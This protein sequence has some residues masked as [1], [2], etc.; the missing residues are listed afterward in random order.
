M[1]QDH[2]EALR[3][4][5]MATCRTKQDRITLV[6]CTKMLLDGR[7]AFC[8]SLIKYSSTDPMAGAIGE[9]DE[10]DG[11]QTLGKLAPIRMSDFTEVPVVLDLCREHVRGSVILD[12]GCSKGTT[13]RKLVSMG[14][15]KAVGVDAWQ[16]AVDAAN[17]HPC[18]Q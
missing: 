13:T 12:I 16:S 3:E 7:V 6:K 9:R 1:D 17:A 18:R 2:A 15:A 8:D 5:V 10:E 4:I 11:C 14:A